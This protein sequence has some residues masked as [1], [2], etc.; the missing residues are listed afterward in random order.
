MTKILAMQSVGIPRSQRLRLSCGCSLD[1]AD[2]DVKRQQ[3]Y[4]GRVVKCA[5]CDVPAPR[6]P[7]GVERERP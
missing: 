3:L 4:V 2:A 6:K 1:V 5:K 7:L